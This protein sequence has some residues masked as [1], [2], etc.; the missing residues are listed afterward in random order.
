MKKVL[1]VA[2]LAA[3]SLAIAHAAQ[4]QE[5]GKLPLVRIGTVSDS[6]RELQPTDI[7]ALFQH[8]ILGLTRGEFDVR[9]PEDKQIKA[10][11]SVAR[12]KAAVDRLLADPDVDIVIAPGVL[13]SNDLARRTALPK[14]VIAPF[15]I[16]RRVQGLPYKNGAS[17]VENL[18][19]ITYPGNIRRD[20]KRFR[21]LVPFNTVAV[22]F[23]PSVIEAIPALRDYTLGVAKEI[24]VGIRYVPVEA[25]AEAALQALPIDIDA[26]Y[27]PPLF[28]MPRTEFD[29]LIEGLIKRRL[30]SFALLGRIDV[31]RGVLAGVA[32][33][34][35]L[36]RL[37]RR[38]ALNVQRILLGEDAGKL[39]V[40]LPLRERLT[41][42]MAT[43]RAIYFSPKFEVMRSAELLF[44]EEGPVKR[45][46]SLATVVREAVGANLEIKIAQSDVA[47]GKENIRAARS[48]LFPQLDVQADRLQIDEDRAGS[49]PGRAEKT[50]S[51]SLVLS[52]LLYSEP[53]FANI[54]IQ[55]HLQR[56]REFDRDRIR[57]DIALDAA[58]A[59][60]DVL[61]AKTSERIAKD[62]VELSRQNLEL[63]SLRRRIGTA[64]PGE[65]FRWESEIATNRQE[66]VQAEAQRSVAEIALNQRLH[67]PLDEGFVTTDVELDDPVLITSQKG[68]IELISNPRDFAIFGDFLVE[69]GLEASPEVRQVEAAIEAQERT[70]DSTKRAFWQPSFSAVADQTEVFS[71][72]GKGDGGVGFSPDDTETTLSLQ[73]SLPL[74]TGGGRSADRS[75]AAEEL[76]GLRLFR[77]STR[78]IV[79]QRI[80]SALQTTRASYAS[81]QLSRAAAEAATK[82]LD[83]VQDSYRRGVLSILDLLDAQNASIVADQVAANA[84]FDFLKDLMGVERATSRFDFFQTPDQ[85]LAWFQEL[86]EFFKER[87]VYLPQ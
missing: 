36:N 59:Y 69:K 67:R 73:L 10:G 24:G 56:S 9:F 63:A 26:V 55:R 74:Y 13:A 57:L 54:A 78:E 17:G 20:F 76:T 45:Q 40:D 44:E 86:K 68:L 84:V 3:L 16:E 64:G 46:L 15:I 62:N 27:M 1:V 81:I 33:A 77:Q 30:P 50:T 23:N 65:V 25:S 79:E 71:R 87:S 31:E 37:A 21:E 75:Q 35:E 32:P 22:L 42:N 19:Y 85:Q 58:N 6:L 5:S 4:G 80:R 14:P 66:L 60:L 47:A 18:S 72:S 52:Q 28:Q 43:A 2:L 61:R 53:T 7:R 11:W 51:G 82:N 49:L 83:L 34:I 8:E 29:R 38:V 39:A 12:V 70:L 41:I 48:A